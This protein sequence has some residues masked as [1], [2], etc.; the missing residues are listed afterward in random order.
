MRPSARSAHLV[1]VLAL[2]LAA[3]SPRVHAQA[4]EEPAAARQMA[5]TTVP[6]SDRV[7]I[8]AELLNSPDAADREE[9]ERRFVLADVTARRRLAGL[10]LSSSRRVQHPEILRLA[11]RDPA[12]SVRLAGVDCL[13]DHVA[14]A[15]RDFLP[16]AFYCAAG[17]AARRTA[18]AD[19]VARITG[20]DEADKKILRWTSRVFGALAVES[21]LL[22]VAAWS[23]QLAV[24][25]GAVEPALRAEDFE[26]LTFRT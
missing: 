19:A 26:A 15:P 25:P 5:G 1:L 16:R 23:D 20:E 12:A 10:A 7:L 4:R 14:T 21:S 3:S 9:L 24:R 17:D 18:L 13:T 8:Q 22:D 6:E 2:A 11:L